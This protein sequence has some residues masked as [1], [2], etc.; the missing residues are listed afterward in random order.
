M[1][2]DIHSTV[3]CRF[4]NL[5]SGAVRCIVPFRLLAQIRQ[6]HV[7]EAVMISKRKDLLNH[8]PRWTAEID[9]QVSGRL[10]EA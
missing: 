1:R 10:V 4:S 2:S 8:S 5:K 6:Y 7:S 3:K 9:C